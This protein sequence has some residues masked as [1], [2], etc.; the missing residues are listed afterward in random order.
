MF[1]VPVKYTLVKGVQFP[2]GYLIGFRTVKNRLRKPG[3]EGRMV[4]LF[5]EEQGGLHNVLSILESM[6][7][8]KVAELQ[9]DGAVS[10]KFRK[11][12]LATTSFAE[13]VVLD[14]PDTRKRKKDPRIEGRYEWIAFYRAHRNDLD[15]LWE[16]AMRRAYE[17][18]GLS[19]FYQPDDQD[20]D[21]DDNGEDQ[22][23]APRRKRPIPGIAEA[24]L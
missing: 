15:A 13:N 20:L 9:D 8:L 21:D 24:D 1:P 18:E 11:H 12:K 16:I 6:I 3:R 4:L 17:T 19:E 23:P 14:E 5:D 2:A 22:D 7:F 10:F